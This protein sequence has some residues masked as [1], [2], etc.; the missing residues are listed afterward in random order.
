MNRGVALLPALVLCALGACTLTTDLDGFV[1]GPSDASRAETG[2]ADDT[3]QDGTTPIPEAGTDVTSPALEAGSCPDKPV[4]LCEEFLTDEK[5]NGWEVVQMAGGTTTVLP[6]D[7][8]ARGLAAIVPVTTA[9]DAPVAFWQRAFEKTVSKISFDAD[10]GYDV[11]PTHS[12]EYHIMFAIR[13]D[14]GATWNLLYLT[15]H[16]DHNGWAIQDFPQHDGAIDY[17]AIQVSPG[18]PHHVHVDVAVGGTASF[19]VDGTVVSANP[20]PG[21]VLAGTPTLMLGITLSGVP[22]TP[23]AV[24]FEHVV[25]TGE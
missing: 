18:G 24:G 5:A 8:G 13:L 20:T 7:G 22:T 3:S 9:G 2:S 11:R 25:F 4:A 12:G 21:F 17:R 6:D 10:F 16:P 23:L 15:D 1:G 14:H 19:A